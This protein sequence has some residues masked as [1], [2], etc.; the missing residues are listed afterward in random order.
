MKKKYGKTN[1]KE[2]FLIKKSNVNALETI[3]A[4]KDEDD[5]VHTKTTNQNIHNKIADFI[6]LYSDYIEKECN[7]Y[8]LKHLDYTGSL[9]SHLNSAISELTKSV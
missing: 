9:D 5:C 1:F 6:V 7:K 2:M 8:Q 4:S 3:R